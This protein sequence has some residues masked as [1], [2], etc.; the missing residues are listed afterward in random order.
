MCVG[1]GG[2]EYEKEKKKAGGDFGTSTE[3]DEFFLPHPIFVSLP[4]PPISDSRLTLRSTNPV[5]IPPVPRRSNFSS[6][7]KTDP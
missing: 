4:K 2:G 6:S 1:G 5:R 3:S 7:F